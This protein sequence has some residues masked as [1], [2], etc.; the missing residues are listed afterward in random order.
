MATIVVG[1][2]LLTAAAGGVAAAAAG[3]TAGAVIIRKK[4]RAKKLKALRKK[5]FGE[6]ITTLKPHFLTDK[7][8]PVVI[9][10]TCRQLEEQ[11]AD[12]EGIFRVPGSVNRIQI[13]A[14]AFRKGY[15]ILFFV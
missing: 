11:G 3:T 6:P 8:I 14:D 12:T 4:R 7:G 13:L 5:L 9:E 10:M 2:L 15:Y 1:G